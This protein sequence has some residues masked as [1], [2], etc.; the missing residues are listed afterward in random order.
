LKPRDWERGVFSFIPIKNTGTESEPCWTEDTD[1]ENCCMQLAENNLSEISARFMYQCYCTQPLDVEINYVSS[2]GN[3]WFN[4]CL[5]NDTCPE[6]LTALANLTLADMPSSCN[7]GCLDEKKSY[8]QQDMVRFTDRSRVQNIT[9]DMLKFGTRR[10][11]IETYLLLK[12]FVD[13]RK[14]KLSYI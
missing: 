8:L 4:E 13:K 10:G 1:L 7:C 6:L 14:A 12:N 11:D 5:I 9:S 3:S 2:C